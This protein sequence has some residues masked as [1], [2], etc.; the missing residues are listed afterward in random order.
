MKKYDFP[1][2]LN[3]FAVPGLQIVLGGIMLLNPDSAT[4]LIA[5]ILGWVLVI[6]GGLSAAPM[7]SG[8]QEGSKQKRFLS[9]TVLALGI[10]L[11]CNPMLLASALGRLLGI[12]LLINNGRRVLDFWNHKQPLPLVDCVC[13]GVGLLLVLVPLSASR[14]AIS[15]VGLVLVAI[16]VAEGIDRLNGRKYL[17]S[18]DDPNIIDAL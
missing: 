3:T 2:L 13:A 8:K 4:T 16:G 6:A 17:E 10:W 15:L 7:L 9:V 18:G 11:L 12:L 5:R 1:T 14:M